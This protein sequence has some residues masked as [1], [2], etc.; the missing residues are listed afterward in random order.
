MNNMWNSKTGNVEQVP[1]PLNGAMNPGLPEALAAGY[2][3]LPPDPLPGMARVATGYVDAGDGVNCVPVPPDM[4]Q[5]DYDAQQLAAQTA[6]QNNAIA[7]TAANLA[8]TLPQRQMIAQYMQIY[9]DATNIF[10]T[11]TIPA[12]TPVVN[13]LDATVIA[14]N[15]QAQAQ[16]SVTRAELDEIVEEFEEYENKLR[17][18]GVTL[19]QIPPTGEIIIPQQ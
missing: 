3:T 19:D 6:A 4:S 14:A 11:S 10:C 7:Q 13:V 5:A 16:G 17:A 1:N 15:I 9:A 2:R 8:A 12:I 18:L